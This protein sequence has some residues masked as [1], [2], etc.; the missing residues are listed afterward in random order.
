MTA[1]LGLRHG[2]NGNGRSS[3]SHADPLESYV[4]S[5]FEIEFDEHQES[6]D[7]RQI[8]ELRRIADLGNRG[9]ISEAMQLLQS[10]ADRYPDYDFIYGWK[11]IL[12]SKCGKLDGARAVV[13]EG[14]ARS[15]SKH[16]LCEDM[17]NI[18]FEWGNLAEAVKWWI[19]SIALQKRAAAVDSWHSYIYLAGVATA[20]GEDPASTALLE[21]V[22]RQWPEKVRLN[23]KGRSQ[24]ALR[25]ACEGNASMR[26]AIQRL[27]AD[28]E[29]TPTRQAD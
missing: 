13:H 29:F 1:T 27:C 22:D 9:E 20:L 26:K 6:R 7:Y 24:V 11:A 16:A 14:L 19:K 17:G 18:E 8:P 25:V 10:I 12:L 5:C 4:N 3:S 21:A 15:R 28:P 2:A 23:G